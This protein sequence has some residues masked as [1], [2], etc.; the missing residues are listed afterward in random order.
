MRSA[1][2]HSQDLSNS[3]IRVRGTLEL[4]PGTTIYIE[5]KDNHVQGNC[6]VRHCTRGAGTYD[7]GLEFDEA[8]RASVNVASAA[9]VD[10]YEFLQISPRAEVATIQRI[11]RFMASRFHP[12]NP[13]TGDP[14]KF[15]RLKHAYEVLSDRERRAEY[16]AKR[17][18]R[19][20]STNPIFEMSEFVNG[21][22]GE[23]NRRLGVLSLLYTRRRTNPEDPRISL[24]DLEKRMGWPREYL[25]FTMWYLRS[26]KYITR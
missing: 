26:M 14:E 11:Y 17:D 2:V 18:N 6:T 20:V 13:T 10:L 12:D 3:G 15:L 9:E 7:I 21:I 4:A 25:D 8:T 5:C 22:G 24:H 19:E 1:V 16:D 23:I